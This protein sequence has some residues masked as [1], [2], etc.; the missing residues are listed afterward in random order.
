VRLTGRGAFTTFLIFAAFASASVVKPRT[1]L[2]YKGAGR[3]HQLVRDLYHKEWR[4][5][6]KAGAAL[7]R[8][9]KPAIPQLLDVL[10]Q[11]KHAEAK[12]AA[13]HALKRM[14]LFAVPALTRAVIQPDAH[15]KI[16]ASW[17]LSLMSFTA[18]PALPALVKNLRHSD[19][20]V[21]AGTAASI[22]FMCSMGPPIPALVRLLNDPDDRVRKAAA[23]S[24]ELVEKVG[25]GARS[26]VPAILRQLKQTQHPHKK[27]LIEIL[28][29]I[30]PPAASATPALLAALKDRVL[31]GAA[32]RALI[33]INPGKRVWHRPLRR[34]LA[35]GKSHG[36]FAAI[37]KLPITCA[38]PRWVQSHLVRAAKRDRTRAALEAIAKHRVTA[39]VPVVR[40]A[41]RDPRDYV[42]IEAMRTLRAIDPGG[43]KTIHALIGAVADKDTGDNAAQVLSSFSPHPLLTPKRLTK[44]IS[45][46]TASARLHL[47]IALFK[48]GETR[49]A[50]TLLKRYA[51]DKKTVHY[52]VMIRAL[53]EQLPH[54]SFAEPILVEGLNHPDWTERREAAKSLRLLSSPSPRAIQALAAALRDDEEYVRINAAKALAG[55]ADTTTTPV[56]IRALGDP[57]IY[58]RQEAMVALGRIG[59]PAK[60]ALPEIRKALSF[61]AG[62]Y[63]ALALHTLGKLTPQAPGLVKL[64]LRAL[65]DPDL[66]TRQQATLLLG[67]QKNPSTN[68][69]AA[70]F[71]VLSRREPTLQRS[72]AYALARLGIRAPRALGVL[73]QGLKSCDAEVRIRCAAALLDYGHDKR[74]MTE[75]ARWLSRGDPELR[76]E[77]IATI[78]EL[79]RPTKA[80]TL[81]LR[82]GK[83]ADAAVRREALRVL[84][85]LP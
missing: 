53:G 75:L 23:Q 12:V 44:L 1:T 5:R 18:A 78:A 39:A 58:V 28:G 11:H 30:G 25:S 65:K 38:L 74:A 49:Q 54:T 36:A 17:V 40:R 9:G 41:L 70:L 85:T 10:Y 15:K 8:I 19:A 62:W 50:K 66:E 20:H 21:R 67:N 4:V 2:G 61:P 7:T 27:T 64:A 69:K 3:I 29:K 24:L 48:S 43:T 34:A 33:V 52:T 68:G 76:L 37:A 81:L 82:A 51:R 79:R 71:R 60:A 14:G 83:D 32:L 59:P 47:A 13:G 57:S 31:A 46:A 73:R 72:A 80:R 35:A 63:R 22:G 16:D 6:V 42:R 45:Q 55:F 77:I 26:A 56:L 84:R